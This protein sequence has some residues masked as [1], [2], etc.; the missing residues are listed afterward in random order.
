M[1]K[2]AAGVASVAL[3]D[4][5]LAQEGEEEVQPAGGAADGDESGEEIDD[6]GEE[7]EG[8]QGGDP[9]KALHAERGKRKQLAKRLKEQEAKLAELTPFVDEYK[10]L[11]PHLPTLLK[12]AQGGEAPSQN[13]NQP[14]PELVELANDFGF[15][16]EQGNPDV[17]RAA[18]V[19]KRI[20]AR[21]GRSAATAVAPVSR[22]SAQAIAAQVRERAYKATDKTTGEPYAT[23]EA[24]DQVFNSLGPEALADPDTATMALIIARGLGGPGVSQDEP[25]HVEGGGR[26]PKGPVALSDFDRT[27]ARLRGRTDAEWRKLQE[28]PA[29]RDEWELEG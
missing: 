10:A 28:A 8:A 16:D 29:G 17:A 12:K 18:R 14:D 7:E 25:I 9:K 5:N 21:A 4:P 3:D 15:V 24:I 27:M 2:N 19:Q 1:A 6:G 22:Q 11:L 26:G 20:D 23:R 13:P